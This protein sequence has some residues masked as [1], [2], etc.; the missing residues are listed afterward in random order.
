LDLFESTCPRLSSDRL[1]EIA[2]KISQ[3]CLRF[4]Q[5]RFI[6]RILR[7]IQATFK[8]RKTPVPNETPTGLRDEFSTLKIVQWN[9]FLRKNRLEKE[10]MTE[11]IRAIRELVLPPLKAVSKNERFTHFW[12]P[13]S[14]WSIVV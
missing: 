7:A 8:S 12:K 5:S 6:Q 9:A 3:N 4:H 14:G 1:R 13:V 11:V 2:S 10:G